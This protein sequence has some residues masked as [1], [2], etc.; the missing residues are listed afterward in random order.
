MKFKIGD[1]LRH[2]L[3]KIVIVVDIIDHLYQCRYFTEYQG[4][5]LEDFAECELEEYNKY[6]K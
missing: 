5:V 4:F 1:V 3:S 2:K 6:E